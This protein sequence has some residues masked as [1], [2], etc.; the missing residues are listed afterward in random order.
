MIAGC[1]TGGGDYDRKC[2]DDDEDLILY[3]CDDDGGRGRGGWSPPHHRYPP[4]DE[5]P[6]YYPPEDE[7][8]PCFPEHEPPCY[9]DNG[10]LNLRRRSL[11]GV[12][13]DDGAAKWHV[14]QWE[15]D[16]PDWDTD[17]KCRDCGERE[18]GWVTNYVNTTEVEMAGLEPG[19]E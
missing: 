1:G 4:E 16:K 3:L 5:Y 12:E 10:K 19:G 7:Y 2:C 15:N 13:E 6:P 18:K 11:E 9:D 8:P 17:N 14:R